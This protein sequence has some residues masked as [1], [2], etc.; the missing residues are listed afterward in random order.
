MAHTRATCVA[1]SGRTTGVRDVLVDDILVLAGR[2]NLEM[3]VR[4]TTTG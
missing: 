3:A 4:V 2:S 1:G